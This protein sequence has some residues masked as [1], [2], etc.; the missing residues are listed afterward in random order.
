MSREQLLDMIIIII[1]IHVQSFVTLQKSFIFDATNIS[2]MVWSFLSHMQHTPGDC[3]SRSCQKCV[4]HFQWIL[5]NTD[6]QEVPS[7]LWVA[8]VTG[9]FALP[10]HAQTSK[11]KDSY[12][13]L[14]LHLFKPFHDP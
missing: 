10:S 5:K 3:R 8:N 6:L 11:H 13:K 1:W 14:V 2:H 9:T 4:F 12:T 7:G